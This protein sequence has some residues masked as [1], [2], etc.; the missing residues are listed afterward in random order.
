MSEYIMNSSSKPCFCLTL[1]YNGSSIINVPVWPVI[2]IKKHWLQCSSTRRIQ[3][4]SVTIRAA[5]VTQ[6][7]IDLHDIKTMSYQIRALAHMKHPRTLFWTNFSLNCLKIYNYGNFVVIMHKK[8]FFCCNHGYIICHYSRVL[9][10]FY[11]TVNYSVMQR[12]SGLYDSI[13]HSRNLEISILALP[14]PSSRSQCV[15]LM[16]F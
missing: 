9:F 11:A 13:E 10:I 15:F 3:F 7:T 6:C 14:A 4:C 8:T 16:G 5:K 12:V 2:Y 1:N